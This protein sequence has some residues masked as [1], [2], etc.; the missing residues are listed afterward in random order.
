MAITKTIED[1]ENEK[2]FMLRGDVDI[3]E[4]IE[5]DQFLKLAHQVG[6]GVDIIN[7]KAFLTRCGYDLTREN[8]MNVDLPYRNYEAA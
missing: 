2:N 3:S 4:K 1:W 7:R 6:A 5:E 8:M